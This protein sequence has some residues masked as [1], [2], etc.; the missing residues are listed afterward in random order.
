VYPPIPPP[1]F[2][3]PP[4]A[5]CFVTARN[6]NRHRNVLNFGR[7]YK[8]I[9]FLYSIPKYFRPLDLHQLLIWWFSFFFLP[10]SSSS[11]FRHGTSAV[12]HH[13]YTAVTAPSASCYH[14][15]NQNVT[16]LPRPS[17]SSILS[18]LISG[19]QHLATLPTSHLYPPTKP[20]TWASV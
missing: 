7:W 20:W 16:S 9:N 6:Y 13:F 3:D 11:S 10:S 8:H 1:G 12:S 4:F 17:R 15:T 19:S 5:Y 14:I 2:M 18:H